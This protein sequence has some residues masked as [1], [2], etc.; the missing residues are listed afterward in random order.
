VKHLAKEVVIALRVD[1]WC[2][3]NAMLA[4]ENAGNTSVVFQ[5]EFATCEKCRAAFADAFVRH[6]MQQT[7]SANAHGVA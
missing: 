7:K 4:G 3:N 5:E 2:G 1:T 6:G